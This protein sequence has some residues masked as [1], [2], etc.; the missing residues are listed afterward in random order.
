MRKGCTVAVLAALLCLSPLSAAFAGEAGPVTLIFP[1]AGAP[2]IEEITLVGED[3]TMRVLP[4]P[5]GWDLAGPCPRM[6]ATGIDLSGVSNVRYYGEDGGFGL[7]MSN[8]LTAYAAGSAA[9]VRIS[10]DAFPET[11]FS[12]CMLEISG[13]TMIDMER[14]P[15]PGDTLYL[16]YGIGGA[17]VTLVLSA[18]D[19]SGYSEL[20]KALLE[21]CDENPQPVTLDTGIGVVQLTA[22]FLSMEQFLDQPASKY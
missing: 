6:D 1:N 10:V 2:Y 5:E 8:Q 20:G 17:Q 21:T 11:A 14:A 4:F 7:L 16:F 19:S 12:S 18:I 9:C 22:T 15:S 3:S 13:F